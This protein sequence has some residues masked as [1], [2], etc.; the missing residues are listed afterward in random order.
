[1]SISERITVFSFLKTLGLKVE[2]NGNGRVK[3]QS[4]KSGE[5]I[6]KGSIIKLE[7]S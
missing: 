1:M 2:F 6:V 4:I 7:L 3:N 5:T